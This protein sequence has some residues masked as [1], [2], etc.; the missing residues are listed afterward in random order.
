MSDRRPI[1]IDVVSDIVCPWCFIGKRRLEKALTLVSEVPVE[2]H[3]RP[4]FLNDWIPPEGMSRE[5]YLTTKFGSPE[6]YQGIAQR[7]RAAAAEEVLDYAVDRISRQPNTR[8][9]HRLI[10]WAEG[11]GKAAD[12]KQRLMD[13][14]FT[15]GADLSDR[16]VLVRAA[17]DVGLDP[18]DVRTALDSDKDI[19]EIDQEVEAAKEAGI[20]GVP[21]FI[22]DGKYAISGA[23]EPEA[24]AQAIMQA[25]AQAAE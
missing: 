22:L 23:Q 19:A 16:A 10:R 1:R 3:W 17:A 18:E 7:V 5:Q 12:M 2:V 9:A 25:S 8:D 14:Y 13:L 4:Y 20:Q 24:L 11:I 6:R 21:C 15:D